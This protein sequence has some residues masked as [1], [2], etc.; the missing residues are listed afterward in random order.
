MTVARPRTSKKKDIQAAVLVLALAAAAA[1]APLAVLTVPAAHAA[2][3][4]LDQDLRDTYRPDVTLT[5]NGHGEMILAVRGD[6]RN[7]TSPADHP[8][9]LTYLASCGGV[10]GLLVGHLPQ[11]T[12]AYITVQQNEVA[13]Q[14]NAILLR[15]TNHTIGGGPHV[16]NIYLDPV[17]SYAVNTPFTRYESAD[18]R[19]LPYSSGVYVY[20]TP[21]SLDGALDVWKGHRALVS[22]YTHTADGRSQQISLWGNA[23]QTVA[24]G[25]HLN[26]YVVTEGNSEAAPLAGLAALDAAWARAHVDGEVGTSAGGLGRSDISMLIAAYPAALQSGF[27][28]FLLMGHGALFGASESTTMRV[29]KGDMLFVLTNDNSTIDVSG[30]GLVQT[31]EIDWGQRAGTLPGAADGSGGPGL[32]PGWWTM[33]QIQLGAAAGG[34]HTL[35]AHD[36]ALDYTLWWHIR[37]LYD[38]GTTGSYGSQALVIPKYLL[39]NQASLVCSVWAYEARMVPRTTSLVSWSTGQAQAGDRPVATLIGTA[40]A[41]V[42][43]E[44]DPDDNPPLPAARWVATLRPN[45][46]DLTPDD[47]CSVPDAS[48]QPGAQPTVPRGSGLAALNHTIHIDVPDEPTPI[49]VHGSMHYTLIKDRSAE[50]H[51]DKVTLRLSP[52]PCTNANSCFAA[53]HTFRIP[54]SVSEPPCTPSSSGVLCIPPDM[55]CTARGV[56][57]GATQTIQFTAGDRSNLAIFLGPGIPITDPIQLDCTGV[58]LQDEGP[59]EERYATAVAHGPYAFSKIIPAKQPYFQQIAADLDANALGWGTGAGLDTG[60]MGVGFIA[61][62]VT[63]SAM[64]GFRKSHVPASLIIFYSIIAAAV[65]FDVVSIAEGVM[66]GVLVFVVVGIFAV[67]LRR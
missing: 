49:Q 50:R 11:W 6:N 14:S 8:W 19:N 63:L 32:S 26:S 45:F 27:N 46:F 18:L 12:R 44:C 3:W 57:S 10:E 48:L 22:V 24:A 64:A 40:T 17:D 41:V 16:P 65:Y 62:M 13:G 43:R 54:P 47:Y 51:P 58:W 1:G 34:T 42:S 30:G 31:A 7:P 38:L 15:I 9:G 59:N 66:A 35:I 60:F 20:P 28:T 25:T 56:T 39:S 52:G 23:R 37:P 21:D 67:G 29:E 53:G 33:R 61:T 4:E 36:S 55:S 5:D 2:L